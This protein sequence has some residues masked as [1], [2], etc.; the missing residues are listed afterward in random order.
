MLRSRRRSALARRAWPRTASGRPP[1]GVPRPRRVADRHPDAR[2]D[3]H[4]V[5]EYRERPSQF[6][7]DPPGHLRHLVGGGHLLAEDDELV[8]ADPGRGVADAGRAVQPPGDLAQEVV[9]DLVPVV[10]LISLNRS[11][12]MDTTPTSQPL[13]R[14]SASA[15]RSRS[16]RRS[17]LGRPVRPSI[18][19]S[20]SISRWA[21]LRSV[22]SSVCAMKNRGRPSPSRTSATAS[23]PRRRCRRGAGS[24][25]PGVR[26]LPCCRAS[27]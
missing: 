26:R 16:M 27:P 8:T 10:S 4:L 12:S 22:M 9:A 24:A 3:P 18:V 6:G 11:G 7:P 23:R 19:V 17:R 5:P 14:A 21:F 20:R 2:R 13:R 1:A 15:W 25:S